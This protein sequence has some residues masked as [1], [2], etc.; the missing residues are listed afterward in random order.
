V[1]YGVLILAML[2]LSSSNC[3]VGNDI[4][5]LLGQIGG[6][7]GQAAFDPIIRN[8]GVGLGKLKAHEI[9]MLKSKAM[10]HP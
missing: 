5:G 1:N 4:F 6:I 2:S 9:E 3:I 7:A 8:L 10:R